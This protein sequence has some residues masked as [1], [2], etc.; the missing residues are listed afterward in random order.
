MF[1][2]LHTCIY[3]AVS[4][5]FFFFN[6][7]NLFS[8]RIQNMCSFCLDEFLTSKDLHLCFEKLFACTCS[9]AF[10][11]VACCC[12]ECFVEMEYLML[13]FDYSYE[14]CVSNGGRELMACICIFF[15]SPIHHY[16]LVCL[17]HLE[18]QVSVV[19]VI[20][21]VVTHSGLQEF[22]PDVT[23]HSL[24]MPL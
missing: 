15:F 13:K 1:E 6:F 9:L 12:Y 7:A 8:Q 5:R 16:L 23:E 11:S 20:L 22:S 4:S 21:L 2:I 17:C 19:T 10:A 14:D 24:P 18:N 3:G